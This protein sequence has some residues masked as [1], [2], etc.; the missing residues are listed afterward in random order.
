ML[1]SEYAVTDGWGYEVWIFNDGECVENYAAGDSQYD[2]Q[3][4]GT[5]DLGEQTLERYARQTA[6][7]MIEELRA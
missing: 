5:G 1:T 2:S 3:I 7:E 4:Y 6:A